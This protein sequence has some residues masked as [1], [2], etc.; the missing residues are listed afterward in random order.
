MPKKDSMPY[1]RA[2]VI[3]PDGSTI[4]YVNATESNEPIAIYNESVSV[5]KL[6]LAKPIPE[7]ETITMMIL[8]LPVSPVVLLLKQ[9]TFK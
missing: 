8:I 6:T 3:S 5:Y 4:V 9:L 1:P 2:F 7:F